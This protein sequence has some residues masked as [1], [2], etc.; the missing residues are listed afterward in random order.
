MSLLTQTDLDNY[1]LKLQCCLGLKSSEM[2]TKQMIGG[3][4][5]GDRIKFIMSTIYLDILRD[6]D[7]N[8]T[9]LKNDDLCTM[10]K[11][12]R[13]YCIGC[14]CTGTLP[15]PKI[16]PTTYTQ[17]TN[18]TE[19]SISDY[20]QFTEDLANQVLAVVNNKLSSIGTSTVK[21]ERRG[22]EVL[23]GSPSTQQIIFSS[24]FPYT[25]IVISCIGID[26]NGNSFIVPTSDL[27]ANGFKVLCEI[28]ATV[29]YKCE[30]V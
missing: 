16:T 25:Y 6:H 15:T 5:I 7:I 29:T 10:L 4:N 20:A 21:Y 30:K 17:D 13:T 2:A 19:V 8:E 14:G 24:V 1:S 28:D 11:Y 27:T 26:S 23:T 12:T 18:T 3:V 22:V 9:C